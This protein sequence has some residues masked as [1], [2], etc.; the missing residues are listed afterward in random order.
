MPTRKPQPSKAKPS[1]HKAPA[2]A[3][4]AK[5]KTPSAP[6]APPKKPPTPQPPK[7]AA[8]QPSKAAV[9]QPSKPAAKPAPSTKSGPKPNGIV[10]VTAREA[11]VRS[12]PRSWVVGTLFGKKNDHPQVK[13]KDSFDAQTGAIHGYVWGRAFG[14]VNR[15]GYVEREA[16]A[17]ET[18][19]RHSEDC[20]HPP[21]SSDENRGY[22]C[23]V[24]AVMTN[25][26]ANAGTSVK[27]KKATTLYG[28]FDKDQPLDPVFEIPAGR[29]V[30]WRWVTKGRHNGHRYV[31]VNF[32]VREKDQPSHYKAG[33]SLW[34]FVKLSDLEELTGTRPC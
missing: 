6:P 23:R 11:Y 28:N 3:A 29:N 9:K 32:E 8:K 22:L 13:H 30:G 4:K 31:M 14:N 1:P 21:T 19:P 17:E 33:T 16:L 27:T 20:G 34:G 18:S 26:D 15:C 7:A 24:F 12:G 10:S 2:P 5:P 25:N